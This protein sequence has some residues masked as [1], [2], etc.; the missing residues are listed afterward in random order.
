[1]HIA[2]QNGYW[3]ILNLFAKHSANLRMVYEKEQLLDFEISFRIPY[4]LLFIA[5]EK[6][7][8]WMLDTVLSNLRCHTNLADT[9]ANLVH[10]AKNVFNIKVRLLTITQTFVKYYINNIHKVIH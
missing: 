5:Y 4:R 6:R 10:N 9:A 7:L 8:K 3:E 2:A 1:M